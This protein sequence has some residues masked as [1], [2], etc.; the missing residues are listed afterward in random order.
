VTGY[1]VDTAELSRAAAAARAVAD[2]SAPV[3]PGESLAGCVPG[4]PGA[5]TV[6]AVARV[7]QRWQESVRDWTEQTEQYAADLD[8]AAAGYTEGENRSIAGFVYVTE[9]L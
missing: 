2:R 8:T 1:E 5:G 6:A 3:D 9:A 7:G 4:M